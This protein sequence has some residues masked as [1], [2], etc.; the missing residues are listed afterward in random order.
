MASVEAGDSTDD[1]FGY[2][3]TLEDEKLLAS[4]ADRAPHPGAVNST[5]TSHSPPPPS[6]AAGA[7]FANRFAPESQSQKHADSLPRRSLGRAPAALVSVART[8]SVDEF[9]RKTQPDSS[10]AA[11]PTD[12]VHYPDRKCLR[13]SASGHL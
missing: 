6:V 7:I 2:D 9:V 1:D 10:H 13:A 4:L 3:L 5:T 12:D 11:V 8:D